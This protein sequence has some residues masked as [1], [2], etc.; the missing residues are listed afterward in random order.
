MNDIEKTKTLVKIESNPLSNQE[1][2][3]ISARQYI[4]S[5]Q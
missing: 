5:A 2:A 4:V 1:M 3:Y